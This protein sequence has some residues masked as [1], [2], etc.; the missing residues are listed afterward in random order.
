MICSLSG[1]LVE[2]NPA[3]IVIEVNGIGYEVFVPLSTF[4]QLPPND[5][6]CRLLTYEHFREDAHSLFGFA[7]EAE[8]KT[9]LLLINVSGIGPRL[10]LATL[11]GLSVRDIRLAV[12]NRDVKRLSSVSGIGKKTAE[13]IVLEL[14][15]K[16]SA[17]EAMEAAAGQTDGHVAKP[18]VDAV[19]AL[20]ALGYKQEEARRMISAVIQDQDAST[21][22]VEDL[23]RH[24]LSTRR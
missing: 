2:K 15:D 9:F 16:I 22:D 13:R 23:V 7:S 19:L 1:T 10:A 24:A 5:Q 17:G 4:D 8:K 14:Q 12:A 20:V 21:L 18:V 6:P 11:S 3:R